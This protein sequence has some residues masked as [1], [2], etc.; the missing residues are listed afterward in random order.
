MGAR[1]G[2][3][4]L[5]TALGGA[6]LLGGCGDLEIRPDSAS[7]KDADRSGAEQ[8]FVD[9]LMDDFLSA[10]DGD[11]TDWKFFKVTDRGFLKLTV[12]WDEHKSVDA[13]VDVRDRFGALLDS[14][15][16]SPELEKDEVELR[17][18]PGTHFVRLYTEKGA[19]VYTIEAKFQAFDYQPPEQEDVRPVDVGQVLLDPGMGIP[20]GGDDVRP[21][22]VDGGRR[23]TRGGSRR[24]PAAG[25]PTR[26]V[27]EP[28]PRNANPPVAGPMVSAT[29]NRII[30][31]RGK[32]GSIIWINKGTEDGI[33]VGS[34][35]YV[36][37]D[38]GSAY[39]R[40]KVE[41]ANDR[42]SQAV[43]TASPTEIAHRRRVKVQAK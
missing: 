37:D 6:L 12:F 8:L 42:A 28:R 16:H 25:R 38:D 31:S 1:S 14:R 24:P 21:M 2:F 19:S 27:A 30:D 43:C 35:G 36:V 10:P 41:K 29:I 34:E 7:G 15:R 18:E 22:A 9:K 20:P 17:V 5:G 23:P 32:K 33:Q 4:V 11:N 3:S 39:A 13:V 40:L 26:P